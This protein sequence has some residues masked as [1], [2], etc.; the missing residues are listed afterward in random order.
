M[1]ELRKLV[2][3]GEASTPKVA[4]MILGVALNTFLIC[5]NDVSQHVEKA[6]G[7]WPIEQIA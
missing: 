3:L 6:T 5:H 7:L 1:K 4:T 2:H